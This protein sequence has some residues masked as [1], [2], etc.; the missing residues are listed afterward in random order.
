MTSIA[1]AEWARVRWINVVGLQDPDTLAA[2][3]KHDERPPLAMEDVVHASSR[4]KVETYGKPEI[5]WP[6]YFLAVCMLYRDE[7]TKGLGPPWGNVLAWLSF[8]RTCQ[9]LECLYYTTPAEPVRIG[10]STYSL[11]SVTMPVSALAAAVSGE[12]R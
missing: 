6:R 9:C 7:K 12:A 10:L 8:G 1:R 11:G 4:P 3:A 5:G 2:L